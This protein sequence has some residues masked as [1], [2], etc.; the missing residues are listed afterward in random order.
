MIHDKTLRVGACDWEH[1]Q[2]Q[3]SFYPEDLPSEWRLSYYAN[4]FSAVLVP[5]AKWQAEDVDFE[6]W[7]EDVP[8]GFR[9]YF[10]TS[11][12]KEKNL[13]IFNAAR[14]EL[15]E[16]FSGFVNPQ[17]SESVALIRFEAKSLRE[18]KGWLQLTDYSA[19][20]LTDDKLSTKQLNDFQ[21]LIEFMGL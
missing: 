8:E 9:F 13:Q 15:G 7:A 1:S 6:Q 18:W 2:W 21:S 3:G 11:Q 20:F 12:A 14:N 5:E 16:L 19:I 17:M 10:L 4:E